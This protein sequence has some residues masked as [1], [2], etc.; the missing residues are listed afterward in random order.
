[1]LHDPIADFLT[2]IRNAKQ[3]RHR[4]VD[5]PLSKQ[6]MHI[7]K[8]MQEQGFIQDALV[9]NEKKLV[10]LMLKYDRSR[11]PAMNGLKRVSKPGRR[12]YIGHQ[13]IPKVLGGLGIAILSTNKGIIEGEKAREQKLGGEIL[14]YI[15]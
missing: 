11:N 10:R 9:N 14:C 6:K 2:R 13:R 3:R 1:M 4:Y 7:A 12:I 5:V 15:W 8:I